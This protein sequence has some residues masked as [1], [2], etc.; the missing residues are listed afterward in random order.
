MVFSDQRGPLNIR[1]GRGDNIVPFGDSIV[2]FVEPSE[3]EAGKTS[4]ICTE[5]ILFFHIFMTH[6]L[7]VVVEID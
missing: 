5:K 3:P 1:R 7:Q 2:V 6:V 4:N